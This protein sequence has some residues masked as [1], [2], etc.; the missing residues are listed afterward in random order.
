MMVSAGIQVVV[1]GAGPV[2]LVA[3]LSLARAGVRVLVLERRDGLNTA[4]LASTI[5]PP[6]LEI[7]DELGVL[8]LMQGQGRVVETIQYRTPDAVFAEF[9][10]GDLARDTRFPFRLHLEQARITPVLLELLREHAWAKVRFG[11]SVVD[12]TSTVDAVAI[13]VAGP[14]GTELIE[15][16]YLLAADGAHSAV[17]A[18][19][20]IGFDGMTYPDKV[21]RVVTRDDLALL[22]PGL[23]P[24]S[25][26]YRGGRSVS[27][28]QMP[29]CWRIILRV[30]GEIS[31][32]QAMDE[33]WILARFQ[34]VLPACTRLPQVAGK[35]VYGASRRV[36]GSFGNGRVS[37][38]G[39]AAHVTNTRGGMNMNCGIYDAVALAAAV[40][41]ALR[42]GGPDL[43]QAA[44]AERHRVATEKLL[45]RTDKTVTGGE[46]WTDQLARMAQSPI[47]AAAYLRTAAM[48]D[49]APRVSAASVLA[50]MV[51]AHA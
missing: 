42:G 25:Y 11:C 28:L 48:L 45:P 31:E 19:M 5:H 26:L 34:A 30:P 36:A 47:E 33:A 29:D 37:L 7:L 23:A 17:R 15:A 43:V 38:M 10:M 40:I 22:L 6:T 51:P 9:H 39:D 2:G 16:A 13:E 3:A 1:V 20:G 12:V 27:F 18:A 46:A 24:V 14:G 49:M 41:A 35:D 32:D 4:S 50:P 8:P 44:A 21:L